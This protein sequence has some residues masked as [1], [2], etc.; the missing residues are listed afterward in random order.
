MLAGR[1]DAASLD[2]YVKDFG[3]RFAEKDGTIHGAYG[4][5]WRTV[6]GFD[7]ITEVVRRLRT[8]PDDRQCVISMWDPTLA[9][10]AEDVAFGQED[11]LGGIDW[12]DRPCNT[13]VY[14]RVRSENHVV[15]GGVI[16]DA[17]GGQMDY[18]ET[19]EQSRKVLDLTVCCRSNDVIWGAYGANAVHFSVLQE[20]LA[21]R[22]GVGVGR[23][24]QL[25]NN[26]HGYVDALDRLGDPVDLMNENCQ[27]ES[28]EVFAEPIGER[29]R[30]WDEDLRMFMQWHDE[31][32]TLPSDS[33][34]IDV[35][36]GLENLWF[37][38]V[39]GN[40][41]QT[42]WLWRAGRRHEAMEWCQMIEASDWRVACQ[43][44]MERRLER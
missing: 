36:D 35:P 31:L 37:Y 14:L 41:V 22:I 13:H 27:Y 43:G 2:H 21:G 32:W 33:G 18:V 39:A 7:Q 8:N 26:F 40:V 16:R 44:W 38:N 19:E 42:M 4:R 1:D 3:E 9:H 24:Y 23:M 34:D 11:F 29:W 6:F 12:K 5:R 17:A 30:S 15:E 10:A 20:Y 25:S 28:G